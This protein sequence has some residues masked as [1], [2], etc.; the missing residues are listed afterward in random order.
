MSAGTGIY[1][2][3]H[4]ESPSEPV[5]F[6]QIWIQPNVKNVKPNYGSRVYQDE[7]RKNKWLHLIS[8]W[9]KA[10]EDKKLIG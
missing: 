5:R 3:E 4:N 10:E 2:S 8:N 6:I 9:Q 1:H 7:E